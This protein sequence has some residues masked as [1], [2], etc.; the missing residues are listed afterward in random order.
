MRKELSSRVNKRLVFIGEFDRYGTKLNWHGFP[1]RT[2]CLKNVIFQDGRKA[3]DHIWFIVG[4]RIDSI[5]ELSCGDKI[6]FEARITTY[7]KGYFKEGRY[8]DYKLSNPTKIKKLINLTPETSS[9][10]ECGNNQLALMVKI[11]K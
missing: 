11:G 7:Q 9:L 6:S 2:I 3:T 10:K 1:E 5:G 4:K 8:L